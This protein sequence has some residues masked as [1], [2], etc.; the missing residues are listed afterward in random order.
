[1]TPSS[2]VQ[3]LVWLLVAAAAISVLSKRVRVPYTAALVVGGILLGLIH[4]R[5]LGAI[6]PGGQPHWLTPDIILI[7]FLPALVFEGSVKLNVRDLF[8]DS[9]PLLVLANVGVVLAAAVTGFLVHWSLGLPLLTALLFGAIIS[10]T[11]PI[12]VLAI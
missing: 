11:D 9:V 8:R 5:Y 1:M 10:A 4:P 2:A 6:V 7:V 3:F 12:S